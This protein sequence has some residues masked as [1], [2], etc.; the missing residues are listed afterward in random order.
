MILEM[1][2][3]VGYS[4]NIKS[5]KMSDQI[6]S[7]DLIDSLRQQSMN[8]IAARSSLVAGLSWSP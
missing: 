1:M 3:T 7:E 8:F 2:G 5:L 4:L 6:R